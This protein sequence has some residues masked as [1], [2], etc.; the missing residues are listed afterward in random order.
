M[1]PVYHSLHIRGM[2]GA[3]VGRFV[4]SNVTNMV[5]RELFDRVITIQARIT[6]QTMIVCKVA[7]Q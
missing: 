5:A 1:I 7:I 3:V 2:D 4:D 6:D